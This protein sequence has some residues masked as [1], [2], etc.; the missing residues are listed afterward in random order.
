MAFA[1]SEVK[2][3]VALQLGQSV[4][5]IEQIIVKQAKTGMDRAELDRVRRVLLTSRRG[6]IK[7]EAA[8]ALALAEFEIRREIV[9]RRESL[10]AQELRVLE[11]RESKASRCNR[12]FY[13]RSHATVAR[14]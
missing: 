2:R 3:L 4:S 11:A 6:Q 5:E 9:T 13:A 8:Y 10:A 14:P 12:R 1:R 7:H